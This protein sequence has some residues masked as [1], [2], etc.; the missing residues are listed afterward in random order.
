MVGDEDII[1][2]ITII[3]ITVAIGTDADVRLWVTTVSM[4]GNRNAKR[5]QLN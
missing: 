3:V 5:K 2:V 4:I 1:I